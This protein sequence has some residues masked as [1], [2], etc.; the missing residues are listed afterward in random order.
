MPNNINNDESIVYNQRQAVF[1][2]AVIPTNFCGVIYA[3][4]VR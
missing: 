4:R 2:C 1:E 3:V